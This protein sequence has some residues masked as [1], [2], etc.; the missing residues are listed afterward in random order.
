MDGCP[1]TGRTS[2]ALPSLPVVTRLGGLLPCRPTAS[3]IVTV[4]YYLLELVI[5]SGGRHALM[6]PTGMMARER[7]EGLIVELKD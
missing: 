4:A 1:G 3:W 5:V 7:V 2:L 6:S